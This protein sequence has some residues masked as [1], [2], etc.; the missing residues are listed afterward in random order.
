M[1]KFRFFYYLKKLKLNERGINNYD[2]AT[3]LNLFQLGI[4][5]VKIEKKKTT[6]LIK[7][8]TIFL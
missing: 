3:R 7:H 6:C 1:S 2:T 5:K 8:S 4:K